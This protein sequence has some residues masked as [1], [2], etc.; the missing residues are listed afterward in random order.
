MATILSQ[1]KALRKQINIPYRIEF[2]QGEVLEKDFQ[3]KV[4]YIHIWI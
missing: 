2:V 4:I 3:D 1:L